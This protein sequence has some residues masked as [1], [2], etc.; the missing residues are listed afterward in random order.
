MMFGNFIDY[1]PLDGFEL[2]IGVPTVAITV[3]G[4]AG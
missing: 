4:L 3:V 2:L 1:L